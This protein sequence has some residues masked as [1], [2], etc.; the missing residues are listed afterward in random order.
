MSESAIMNAL[1]TGMPLL[2]G[3]GG[4]FNPLQAGD[5][6]LFLWLTIV[7]LLLVFILGKTLWGPLM[8]TIEAREEKI[9]GDLEEAEKAREAAEVTRKE[10]AAELEA[11][12][13]KAKALLEEA[14]ERAGALG[15]ELEAKARADAEGMIEKARKQIEAEKAQAIEDI[16]GQLVELSMEITRSVVGKTGAEQ[17]HLA[18][19]DRL[20]E[21]VKK[22]S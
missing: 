3:G 14:R 4:E 1:S 15:Q 5:W 18:E 6:S 9:R 20:I 2:A 13:S 22:A 12:A 10:H 7:F 17:D 8:K 16:R 21:K 11:A 19:A